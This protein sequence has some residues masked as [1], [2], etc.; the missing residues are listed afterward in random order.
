MQI[1]LM[2]HGA[3]TGNSIADS[4]IDPLTVDGTVKPPINHLDSRERL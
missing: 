2:L 1:K 4:V 3:R